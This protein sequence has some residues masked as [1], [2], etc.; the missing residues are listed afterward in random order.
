MSKGE[1]AF[2]KTQHPFMILKKTLNKVGIEE[3]F[4]KIIKSIYDKH[5]ANII[6]NGE[7][8]K[9]FSLRSET[10][11]RMATLAHFVKHNI[12]SPSHSNQTKRKINK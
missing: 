10:K 12:G 3:T 9:A 7:K 5:T 1:K 2:D 4:L 6:S 8:L 11:A